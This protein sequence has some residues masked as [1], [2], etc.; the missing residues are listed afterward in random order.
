MATDTWQARKDCHD[1]VNM[2]NEKSMQQSI[3]YPSRLSFRI[4]KTRSFKDKQKLK[5]F[6]NS[7]PTKQDILKEIL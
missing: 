6:V 4:V 5:V 2:L 3:L 7:K 1:I